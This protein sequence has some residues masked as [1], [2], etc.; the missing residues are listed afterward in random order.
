M[1]RPLFVVALVLAAPA[2]GQTATRTAAVGQNIDW[3]A[4]HDPR[5]VTYEVGGFTLAMRS[6][7]GGDD[8][9]DMMHLALTVSM[10]GM[11]PVTVD[12]NDTP[13]SYEHRVTIG[14]WD[15]D[16]RYVLFQSFSGGAH[17]C[18]NFKAIIPENGRLHVIDLGDHDGDYLDRMPRD[19]DGDGR[20][21]FVFPDGNFLYAFASYAE[22]YPP[23][24]VQNIVDDRLI[25]VSARPGF[26]SLFESALGDARTGCLHSEADTN[27]NGICAAYVAVAARLGRFDAAWAEML[28]AYKRDSDW[29]LPSGCR[30]TMPENEACPDADQIHYTD[31]P[32]ALRH[33]LIEQHYIAR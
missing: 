3:S 27:P 32:D 33:F 6:Q 25:D 7:S 23:P 29:E 4:E 31:Y 22:S 15:A 2:A 12:G 5:P 14:N 8:S 1:I 20:L 18:T 17:C 28:N 21:D 26:R 16:T 9:P 13:A 19:I 24:M 11:A 30:R 10:P